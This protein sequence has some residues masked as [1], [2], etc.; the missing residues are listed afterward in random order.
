MGTEQK[1]APRFTNFVP[2]VLAEFETEALFA[3]LSGNHEKAFHLQIALLRHQFDLSFEAAKKVVAQ[4][5][6]DI[7]QPPVKEGLVGYWQQ[8]SQETGLNF[9]ID[10]DLLTPEEPTVESLAGIFSD[11]YGVEPAKLYPAMQAR[12]AAMKCLDRNVPKVAKIYYKENLIESYTLLQA[13]IS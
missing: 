10:L 4:V 3:D 6:P 2:L 9:D 12:L 13:A 5:R 11:I 8:L 1:L 7:N